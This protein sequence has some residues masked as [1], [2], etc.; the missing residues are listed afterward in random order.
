MSTKK[1]AQSAAPAKSFGT[2]TVDFLT[3]AF[4][5]F[6]LQES[7]PKKFEKNIPEFVEK[8]VRGPRITEEEGDDAVEAEVEEPKKGKQVAKPKPAK[9]GKAKKEDAD[10]E[11]V[12]I[13]IL[14]NSSTLANGIFFPE[15]VAD[16]VA[17]LL[18]TAEIMVEPKKI[19]R[20][21]PG[22]TFKKD[23]LEAVRDCL[24]AQFEV[25]E[26]ECEGFENP[27]KP[28]DAEKP[29]K[30]TKAKAAKPKTGAAKGKAG[31]GKTAAAKPATK[32][33][34]KKNK[35]KNLAIDDLVFVEVG[36]DM[37]CVGT[38]NKEEK[39]PKKDDE[40]LETC[41]ELDD[42]SLKEV[43][44]LEK[45]LKVKIVT[46]TKEYL[47]TI[48]DE[49]VKKRLKANFFSDD[50]EEEEPAEDKKDDEDADAED[51]DSA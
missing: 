39:V 36:E 45:K 1:N 24:E 12:K 46:L 42:D 5:A 50:T 37:V 43:S 34:V 40:P 16:E 7:L 23:K 26:A 38:Q 11:K 21:F 49:D 30:P 10:E 41:F 27:F 3:A 2:I 35:W 22:F 18:K 47:E 25:E 13:Y 31:K 8:L 32:L 28:S 29:T 6:S 4:Q 14:L 33:P 44:K 48:E 17:E 19:G 51:E 9:G 20:K 15:D